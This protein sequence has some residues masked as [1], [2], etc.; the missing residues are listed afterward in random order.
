MIRRASQ[1][2]KPPC[3]KESLLKC[4]EFSKA[5]RPFAG[6][7]ASGYYGVREK[8]ELPVP[9]EDAVRSLRI[10]FPGCGFTFLPAKP[11]KP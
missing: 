8:A 1:K 2:I 5:G 11:V 6:E 9:R 3:E 4:L 7:P 10:H